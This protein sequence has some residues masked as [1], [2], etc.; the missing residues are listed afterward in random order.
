LHE[1]DPANAQTVP[2]AQAQA[3]HDANVPQIGGVGPNGE[4]YRC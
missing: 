2:A 3:V 1:I 4:I